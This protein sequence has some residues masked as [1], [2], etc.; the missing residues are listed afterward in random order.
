MATTIGNQITLDGQFT[1]WLA[2]DAVMTSGNTVAGYQVYGAFLTDATLGNTYVIGID[3]TATTDAAIVA[4]T[5]IYLNTDQNNTTGYSPFGKVGAEYEVQFA[6]DSTGALQPYLYSVTSAGVTTQL[7]SGV[8]L[9]A[10]FS[11]DGESVELAIP[12]AL[13][14]PAGGVAPTSINFATLVNGTLGLPGD[15]ATNPE[16]TITDPAAAVA[17]TIGNLIT[18]DGKFSDW[19]ASDIVTNPANVTAGY[20]VYGAFLNDATLGNTY[21]IGIDATAA[22]DPVIGSSDIIYLNTDQNDATGYDLSFANIGAEYEVQF[23]YGSNGALE[24]FLYSVTSAGVATMLNGGAPLDYGLSSNG[25]SVELAIPQALLTPAGGTAPTS[26]NFVALNGSQGLPSD[27]AGNPEFTITDTATLAVQAPTHKVAI[28]YSDT[29]AALY[30]SQTAYADLF[31]AAQNQARMAG[32][33]YDIIDESQLT[34]INNLIGYD[35]IIFPSMA[36]V[37]TA[38]LPAIMSTLI[39]AVYNYHIGIITAGD[40]L[41]NDQT[42]APLPGNAYSNMETLL[43]LARVS[44]GNSGAISVTANDVTNPIMKSYTA[45]QVIQTYPSEGYAAYQ[46]VGGTATDVLVNQTVTDPTLTGGTETIPGVIQT[47]TGGTNVEFASQDLL[48]DS[49]LLSNAIQAVAL[50]TQPGVALHISRDAGVVAVRMDMDQSQFPSDVSPPVLDANGNPTGAT[51]PGIYDTLIPILQQWNQQYNFVGSYFINV[52]DNPTGT[53][54]STTNWTVNSVYYKELLAM[55]SEIGTH[56]YTHLINPPTGTFTAVTSGDTKAGST[57]I[58]LTGAP[59]SF[60]GVTVGMLVTASNGALGTNTVLPGAAGEGGAIAN[61]QVTAVSGDTITISYVPG[62]FGTANDGTIGDI[63]AGTTLTFSIPPENTNFLQTTGTTLSGDGEPFTYAY[64]F[65][66]SAALESQMLGIPIEGAAIPGAN[67]TFATD[68]NILPYFQSVA[69]TATTP[70]YTGFLT[71]GWT[72]IG[73]GYPSAIGYMSPSATDE[74]SLYIAPNMTFDFTEVQYEGKTVAQAEADWAAQ[75]AALSA[76]AAGTPVVVLPIHDYGVAAWN[77]TTDAPNDPT[78][79]PDYYTTAMYTQFIAQAYADNYEFLTLEELAARDEAQQKAAINYTTVG[80]TI[81]A[82]VT[83]DPSAPDVGGMALSVVNG[84]TEVIQN[85]TNWYAYNAQE[86]FLPTNGG[87]FAIN[88]G[89]TQD[90]VTHIES[91]PMRGDLLS[92]TG[93]GLNLSFAMAGTGDVVV[94]LANTATPTVTGATVVSD[95]GNVLTLSLTNAGTNNVSILLSPPPTISG[96]VA[97][98]ATTD[99]ATI[100]PFS[101]VTVADTNANQTETVTVTLSTPANGTLSNLGG[102]TYNAATGIYTDTGTA[103]AVTAALDALVF[104]PTANQVTPGL[105]VTTGFTISDKDTVGATATDAVTTVVATDVANPPTLTVPPSATVNQGAPTLIA[106]LSLAEIANVTGETFTVTLADTSGLLSATGTGVSG[107][108]TT[109]LTITG[110]LATVNADLA[111][112]SDTDATTASDTIALNAVDSFGVAAA[113]QS[114]AV[115]VTPGQTFTLTT[116]SDTVAGGATSN[117]IIAKTA[118]LTAGDNINGGTATNT[119]ALQGGGTFNLATPA[120][121]MN[122]AVITAQEG[123][124][125]TAQTVTLRAGLNVTVNVA[126]P[127]VASNTITIIGA[128]NSDVINLGSGN[129]TVTLGAGET[130]NSG[131]GNN[132]FKVASA[133]LGNVTINGGTIGS[134]TLSLTGGGTATMGAG[135]TGIST[136]QLA[137]ATTFT[138]NAASGLTIVGSAGADKITAGGASQV[139]TGGA[140]TN[141]LTGSSAGS[142]IFRDTAADLNGDTIV[143][144][145]ASDVIDFTDLVPATTTVSKVTISGTST[146][147]TLTSGLTSSKVTLSGTFDGNFVLAADT[148]GGGGT[149]LTFVPSNLSNVTLPTTPVTITTGPV[150]TT[151]VATAGTLNPADKITGGTGTGVVNTLQL[152]G[153]GVFDLAAVTKLTNI[154]IIAA[155]EGQGAAAQT[156]TLKA[157]LNNA[158]VNV[159]S[160]TGGGITIIGANNNDVINLGAGNDTVTPGSGETVNGG[161]GGTDIYNVTKSTIGNV[162]IKGGIGSNTLVVTG[163]GNATMGAKITGVNAV[164]LATTTTFTANTTAGLQISGSSTGGDTITLGAPTQSVIAGGPNETI[165]ATAADAGAAISGLG[166]NSTL[167]ITSGGTITLNAAT[168]VKTVTLSAASTLLLNNKMSFVAVGSNGNDKITAGG[169]GQT[170]TGGAGTDTLTGY[171]GG[172]DI[173]K[174]TAAHL[175]GDTIAGFVASDT[176]DLTNLTF[177]G[178]TVTAVPNGANTK[179]TVASGGTKSVFMIA[180]GPWS[181]TGSFHL[182]T[183]GAAGTFLTHT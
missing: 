44:G 110:S 115:A 49:N 6:L 173:F 101:K 125:T 170:L 164:Q 106:G 51:S 100:A 126:D 53:D 107:A 102:G 128:A 5:V 158:T 25:E 103:A 134:N 124:G 83:P 112:L 70:G 66:Q 155:Q 37:N 108:G 11:S 16:Y 9:D 47:T 88:L 179:V 138:A 4:G 57:T 175:N 27:L 56:S 22:T 109:S 176:I 130:V 167:Q 150:S 38:E 162:T 137:S 18:L 95:V 89:T 98:Q 120:T 165:K 157:A 140:G 177:A 8:P 15:F 154:E 41:T 33:S 52:G 156:V 141:T 65:Q 35:A 79:N 161:A 61:S 127:P 67:E 82:T 132:T 129:D 13:L 94:D 75:F 152:S 43:G 17:T 26:I 76:N 119:I 123:S 183:D 96:T 12:Q 34:N 78:T 139:L 59:P 148:T 31:M 116:G 136:V 171:S 50:G 174:D 69:A 172:F 80:N 40:F 159:A 181:A 64:E 72:G 182:A 77:T 1:D 86:L 7:N 58:T 36:D 32:V 48:G 85:V 68:Q 93:D 117:M 10:G 71:G 29:T 55:G 54:P 90:A 42:G 81:T 19:P 122:V 135:I 30:F 63:P 166:A 144:L 87:T 146:V 149:D 99:L 151:I 118:T 111:T 169:T 28:V 133:S 160:T 20:Q 46:A 3:A 62:G 24:P 84:G 153:G 114:I 97:G 104:V 2:T 168:D 23:A 180:A 14:T 21:V 142:D 147:L 91:L 163:G 74:G 121:L 45:G 178:A 131:G 143:N 73:S 145:L 105:T 92:V 60:A 113:P 39:S